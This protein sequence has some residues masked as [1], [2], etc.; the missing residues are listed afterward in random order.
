MLPYHVCATM[1]LSCAGVLYPQFVHATVPLSHQ[2]CLTGTDE[3][4]DYPICSCNVLSHSPMAS[5]IPSLYKHA[6]SLKTIRR[7]NCACVRSAHS[8]DSALLTY[9]PSQHELNCAHD[10]ERGLACASCGPLLPPFS[11]PPTSLTPFLVMF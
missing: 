6:R 5:R 2:G 4:H 7:F 10:A 11:L 1:D 8:S 9:K 3:G